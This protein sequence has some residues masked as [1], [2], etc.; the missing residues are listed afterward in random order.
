MY[1]FFDT[2]TTGLPKN[3]KAPITDSKNWPRMVQIAWQQY[4]R[5]GEMTREKVYIITPEGYTIPK[6]ASDVHGI[7]T[8][9]AIKEG[10][11]L[12][13]VLHEFRDLMEESE[14]LAAHNIGFDERI[15][16]A[17]FIRKAV[18]SL[19]KRLKRIDTM[20]ESTEF[21]AIPGQ[22]GFKWPNLTE[23]HTILFGKGFEGAHDALADVRACADCYFELKKRKIVA[24]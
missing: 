5:Q 2:E 3:Y 1:L 11:D 22:Y 7:T 24:H 4:N 20:K 15:L 6:E 10:V 14:F 12:N 18:P 19:S 23:L 13:K 17:E 9:R 21:C 16:G 8:E